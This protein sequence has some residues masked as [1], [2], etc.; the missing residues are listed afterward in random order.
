[1]NLPPLLTLPDEAAYRAHYQTNYVDCSP[2]TTFDGYEVSFFQHNFNHSFFIESVRGSHV[3]DTFSNSR[4]ERMDWIKAVLDNDSVELY[5]RV[6]E[7][8]GK[9][10]RIAL[11]GDERYAVIIQIG[12][13]PNQ[14]RFITAYVVN[15]DSALSNMRSN[16]GW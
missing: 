10:R 7:D 5:R 11:V 1:M 9:I 6:M 12:S 2:I 3:K 15:S 13:R 8:S 14:A 4:A 16:P